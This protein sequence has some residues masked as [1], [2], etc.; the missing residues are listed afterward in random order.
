MQVSLIWK[1]SVFCKKLQRCQMKKRI[2][3]NKLLCFD[4]AVDDVVI[5]GWVRTR[6]DSK[7]FSFIEVNDGS[8]L[9]NIQVIADSSIDNYD[10][11]TR[12]ITGSAVSVSGRLADGA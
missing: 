8:C 9:Q 5:K 2:K 7:G 3:I 12:L 6:R 1:E 4:K 11:I 10:E